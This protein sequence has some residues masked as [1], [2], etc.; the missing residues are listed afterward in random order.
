[1]ALGDFIL[2]SQKV[3]C[4][5][6]DEFSRGIIQ[7]AINREIEHFKRELK[8]PDIA[9]FIADDIKFFIEQREKLIEKINRIPKC[10]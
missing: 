5:C 10:D 4:R 6:I 3:D 9:D 7:T 1:M 2:R 8:K